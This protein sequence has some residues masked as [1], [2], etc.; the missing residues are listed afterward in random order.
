MKCLVLF[1]ADGIAEG[2][3]ED[4]IDLD[5]TGRRGWIRVSGRHDENTETV[6][7]TQPG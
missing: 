2:V 3:A 4:G 1:G 5:G 6:I 7:Q